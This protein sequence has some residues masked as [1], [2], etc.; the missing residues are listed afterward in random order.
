MVGDCYKWRIYGM[1]TT[2]NRSYSPAS[3]SG[4]GP[5]SMD[6]EDIRDLV[7]ILNQSMQRQV[8]E[9]DQRYMELQEWH[10][11][12]KEQLNQQL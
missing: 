7:H 8:K 12:A 3:M 10:E 6:V 1:G 5:I 4:V 2:Y 11:K 9:A